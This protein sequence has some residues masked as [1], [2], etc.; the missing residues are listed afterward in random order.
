MTDQESEGVNSMANARVD[1]G[2]EGDLSES[3][4][5]GNRGR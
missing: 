2:D 3:V 5:S 4:K 1:G